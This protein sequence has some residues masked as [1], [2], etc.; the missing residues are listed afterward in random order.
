MLITKFH[1]IFLCTQLPSDWPLKVTSWVINF[2]NQTYYNEVF[3]KLFHLCMTSLKF[4]LFWATNIICAQLEGMFKTTM[5]ISFLHRI[6]IKTEGKFCLQIFFVTIQRAVRRYPDTPVRAA[7]GQMV[8]VFYFLQM[9][10]Q[11][12]L[13]PLKEAGQLT[14]VTLKTGTAHISLFK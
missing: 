8:L 11:G 10:F 2:I 13:W 6:S 14:L 12:C 5:L 9:S 4:D 1:I 7:E 3:L